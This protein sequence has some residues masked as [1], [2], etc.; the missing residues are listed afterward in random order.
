[1]VYVYRIW[2]RSICIH[3]MNTWYMDTWYEYLK[4]VHLIWIREVYICYTNT[5]KYIYIHD[6]NTWWMYTWYEY[7]KYVYMMWM[8]EGRIRGINTWSMYT[9][10]EYVTYVC[11]RWICGI[12]TVEIDKWCLWY[13]VAVLINWQSMNCIM[14]MIWDECDDIDMMVMSVHIWYV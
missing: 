6:M 4:Y 2:I 10:N 8:R 14:H 5:W 11:L 7:M 9:W 3:V 1:M 12:C 13:T